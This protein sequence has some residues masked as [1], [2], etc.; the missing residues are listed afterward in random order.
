[1]HYGTRALELLC[2]YYQGE[3]TNLDEVHEMSQDATKQQPENGGALLTE[4]LKPRSNLPPLLTN[5]AERKC[6]RLHYIGVSF[7]ITGQLFGFWRK[8]NF[9][10]VYLRQ[11]QVILCA[12]F[13]YLFAERIDWGTYLHY[14]ESFKK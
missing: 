5:V 13:T 8:T 4:E 11:T 1:M 10:P 9:V 7:G 14:A 12:L 3:I 6:E 2:N